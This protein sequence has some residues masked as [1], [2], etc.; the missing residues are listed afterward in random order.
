[1][2]QPSYPRS[3]HL[4]TIAWTALFDIFF[5]SLSRNISPKTEGMICQDNPN[6]PLV[7]PRGISRE[8]PV[9]VYVLFREGKNETI[10]IL[11]HYQSPCTQLEAMKGFASELNRPKDQL[12]YAAPTVAAQIF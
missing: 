4:P 5:T 11:S 1:M 10:D 12:G 8:L 2:L 6:Q 7:S 3:I 9:G